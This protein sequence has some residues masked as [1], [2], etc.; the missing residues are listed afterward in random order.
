MGVGRQMSVIQK[1]N[2]GL[3]AEPWHKT[4]RPTCL[5]ALKPRAHEQNRRNNTQHPDKLV[6]YPFLRRHMARGC[7]EVRK[8]E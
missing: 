1:K 3:R 6:F 2:A 7:G 4:R 8:N 5:K